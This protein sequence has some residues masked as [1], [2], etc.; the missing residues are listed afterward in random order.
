MLTSFGILQSAVERYQA[1]KKKLETYN[2]MESGAGGLAAGLASGFLVIAI[3][4]FALEI[5]VMFYAIGIAIKCTK[6]G[7]ERVIHIVLAIAFTFPYVLLSLLFN[8]C[9]VSAVSDI[10]MVGSVPNKVN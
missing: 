10:G 2:L 9:A 8:K 4:F 1:H 6:G 5:L 7:S 3:I